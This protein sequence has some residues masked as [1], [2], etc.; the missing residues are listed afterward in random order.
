C[1]KIHSLQQYYLSGIMDEFKN[2]EIW[3]SRKLKEETLGP[4]GL[5]KL[6]FE[7]YG[8]ISADEILNP[9]LK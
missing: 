3:C 7:I 2:L 8:A 1:G 5:R 9:K 4:E 6:A